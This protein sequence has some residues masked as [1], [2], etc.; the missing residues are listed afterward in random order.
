MM[1]ELFSDSSLTRVEIYKQVLESVGI[2][3]HIRNRLQNGAGFSQLAGLPFS[4]TLCVVND[5]DYD[6]ARALLSEHYQEAERTEGQEIACPQC[7]ETNPAN[8]DICW[9]CSAELTPASTSTTPA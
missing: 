9:S 4:P 1:K 8:F 7:K 3:T 6:R 2:R 5:D